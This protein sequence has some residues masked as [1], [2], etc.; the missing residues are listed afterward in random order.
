MFPFSGVLLSRPFGCIPYLGT[1]RYLA[2]KILRTILSRH[3]HISHFYDLFGGGGAMS[4]CAAANAPQLK[5][6]HYND[7]DPAITAFLTIVQ[8]WF[9]GQ[10]NSFTRWSDALLPRE[11]Y[12]W[13]SRE[14]FNN[15]KNDPTYWGGYLRSVWSFS[16]THAYLY[17]DDIISYKRALFRF[18]VD[19]T[20]REELEQFLSIKL[21]ISFF[22]TTLEHRRQHFRRI[23]TRHA[24][25]LLVKLAPTSLTDIQ[26]IHPLERI[27]HI[28]NCHSIL[29]LSRITNS[30]YVEVPIL[31]RPE[32]VIYVD[33][34]YCDTGKGTYRF[35]S[36]KFDYTNFYNWCLDSKFP[37]YISGYEMPSKFV[38]IC[39]FPVYVKLSAYC[40]DKNDGSCLSRI[41][42]LFWNGK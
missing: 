3:P 13:Q 35:G 6:I 12:R 40:H 37:V 32:T 11:F 20:D 23:T 36:E 33:P 10:C 28:S 26:Q 5:T 34:P 31:D 15:S 24:P 19:G 16:H 4:L 21:P 2:P 41:E 22:Q 30:S 17:A 38:P 39:E 29:K 1:K 8:Q 9:L 14:D 7:I 18:L 27:R 42:K 25:K